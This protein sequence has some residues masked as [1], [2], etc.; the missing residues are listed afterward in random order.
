MFNLRNALFATLLAAPAL[1]ASVAP[2][3]AADNIVYV[4]DKD[5]FWYA[6]HLS[7]I[8]LPSLTG[9]PPPA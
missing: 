4:T 5:N 9:P 7:M 8:I 1:A 2:R 3:A 6:F